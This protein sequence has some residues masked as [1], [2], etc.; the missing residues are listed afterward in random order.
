MEKAIW[1]ADRRKSLVLPTE[2]SRD[3]IR[4]IKEEHWGQLAYL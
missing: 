1:Q 4:E 3:R 2:T